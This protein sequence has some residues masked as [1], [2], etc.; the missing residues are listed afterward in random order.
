M[1]AVSA[2]PGSSGAFDVFLTNTG[3]GSISIQGFQ[4]EVTTA[5]TDITFTDITINPVVA[6]YMFAGN[7]LLAIGS[8]ILEV[9]PSTAQ[10]AQ[11]LDLSADGTSTI[12]GSGVEFGLGEV[13]FSIASNAAPTT[14]VI[15]FGAA[16]SLSDAAGGSIPF[17]PVAGG[18][19]ITGTSAT[20]E[21]A[22]A[23][24]L[25]ATLLGLIALRR[26]MG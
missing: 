10:D 18:L 2:S 23:G 25:G 21:P 17:Q 13:L 1:T 15:N 12:I 22:T 20:P 3:P 16:T 19:T 14:A 11:A 24:M 5:D 9:P 26:R 7:S 6:P 8:S 4:F